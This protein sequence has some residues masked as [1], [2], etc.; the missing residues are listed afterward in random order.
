MPLEVRSALAVFALAEEA[1]FEDAHRAYRE[2][3][4]QYHPDRV[5]HLGPE[6]RRV[7]E[8]KTKEF[9]TAF[10]ILEKFYSA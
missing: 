3:V 8:L 5:A 1:T 7:A 9:N 6:L 10:Q 2:N 4:K